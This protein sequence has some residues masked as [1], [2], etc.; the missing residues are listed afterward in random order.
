MQI[1]KIEL[2]LEN[3]EVVVVDAKYIGFL[4]IDAVSHEITNFGINDIGEINRCGKFYIEL[5]KDL[6]KYGVAESYLAHID[7]P[8][9]NIFDRL[10]Y[11]NDITQVEIHY[12]N[13][14]V[15]N[16][17]VDYW[18]DETNAYQQSHISAAGHL[19][20]KVNSQ[21]HSFEDIFG[22]NTLNNPDYEWPWIRD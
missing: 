16:Y 4:L 14:E 15:K 1:K 7:E 9:P 10:T 3:C 17:Y 21:N 5:H 22:N 6:D 18:G 19:Y 8:Q 12:D 13:G 11:F 2:V 20:I